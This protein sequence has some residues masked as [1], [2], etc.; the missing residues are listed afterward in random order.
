MVQ[1][2]FM[3][4]IGAYLNK[5]VKDETIKIS[6]IKINNTAVTCF[7]LYLIIGIT[8]YLLNYSGYK[9][10]MYSS[11][12][13]I[14]I[15]GKYLSYSFDSLIY[16]DPLV[17][18]QSICYFMFFKNI[19]IKN[20][21]INIISKSTNEVYLLH[22]NIII[23]TKI[24]LLFGLTLECYTYKAIPMAFL[25]SIIICIIGYSIY[26]LRKLIFKLIK[27]DKLL[28]YA[29]KKIMIKQS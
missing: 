8:K 11:D 5:Y 15:V 23:R 12:G 28:E 17:I 9:L 1:F 2:I 4:L 27:I 26:Y 24:Y 10:T 29:C 14:G 16:D 18:I 21:L 7:I 3:Y 19:N 25:V 13:I 6:K 20:K 22:M